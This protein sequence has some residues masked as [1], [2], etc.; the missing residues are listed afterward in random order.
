MLDSVSNDYI[1]GSLG[2]S[3]VGQ[4]IEGRTDLVDDLDILSEDKKEMLRRR[5]VKLVF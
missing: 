4:K 2:V 5:S 3:D 1:G